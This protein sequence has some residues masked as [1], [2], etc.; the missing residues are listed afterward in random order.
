MVGNRGCFRL[1]ASLL[2]FCTIGCF[3]RASKSAGLGILGPRSC[4]CF[5]CLLVACCPDFAPTVWVLAE[6]GLTDIFVVDTG[7]T[8][9][10]RLA[11]VGS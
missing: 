2:L 9:T 8:S 7:L 1:S 11:N 6:E 5:A 3:S 4:C 10:G